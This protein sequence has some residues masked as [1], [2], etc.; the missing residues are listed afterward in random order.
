MDRGKW[1]F[2]YNLLQFSLLPLS[3]L[4]LLYLFSRAK[5][6]SQLPMRL[7]MFS[8]CS[9]KGSPVI[10]IHALSL[11][12]VNAAWPFIKKVRKNWPDALL[13]LT[14]TT[15]TGLDALKDKASQLDQPFCVTVMPF[16]S[17]VIVNKFLRH[18]RP[19]CFVLIETDVWPN[20]IWS[21]EHA[22]IPS[23]FASGSISSK[24]ADMSG[25]VRDFFKEVYNSFSLISMQSESDAERLVSLGIDREKVLCLGNLKFDIDLP[26]ISST[27]RLSLR[28]QF[29]F[30]HNDPILVL[31][32]THAGEEAI[33]LRTYLELKKHM[34]DL[35][36]VIAPRDIKRSDEIHRLAVSL[37]V[38]ALT[39]TG[40]LSDRGHVSETLILDTLGE[41][42]GC[43]GIAD[44]AFVGGSL[45][46]VGGHN[47]FE[48][49]AR[50]VPVIFGPYTESCDDMAKVLT[51]RYAGERI[52]EEGL[53][54]RLLELLPDRE[55]LLAM[56]ERARDVVVSLRG[57]V[58]MHIE[59]LERLLSGD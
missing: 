37:G 22:G 1:S 51:D 23:F 46:P 35:K 11:G 20:T 39:R 18:Y 8:D 31:G 36:M 57:A 19:D 29:G 40:L 3:P 9:R 24:A 16:D 32:S 4:L 13:L 58:D 17:I 34:P 53:P 59:A 55:Q 49:A 41:L 10:W 2:I 5:Y 25:P 6:R 26:D 47:L 48:P 30:A 12:E 50:G 42:A 38:K 54:D 44:L 7:G 52:T 15:K 45:V 56:G 14:A 28:E 33:F 27:D 43:Y 21:L